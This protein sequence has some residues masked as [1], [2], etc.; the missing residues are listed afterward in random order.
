MR[1]GRSLTDNTRIGPQGGVVC[2]TIASQR[3][4]AVTIFTSALGAR[5][6]RCGAGGTAALAIT[7]M[8][9][10]QPR[11]GFAPCQKLLMTAPTT[12]A[13]VVATL[14]C[15][16]LKTWNEVELVRPRTTTCPATDATASPSENCETGG[17]SMTTNS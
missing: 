16:S 2:K 15:N 1:T 3:C 4:A 8:T 7:Q 9:A 14:R 12:Q 11:G 13:L 10:W 5:M 17:V 6:H